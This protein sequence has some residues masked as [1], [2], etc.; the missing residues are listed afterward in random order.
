MEVALLSCV[1]CSFCPY[2]AIC[3]VWYSGNYEVSLPKRLPETILFISPVSVK[4][5]CT[6]ECSNRECINKGMFLQNW[7]SSL[8]PLPVLRG[9]GCSRPPSFSV[10]P[11]LSNSGGVVPWRKLDGSTRERRLEDRISHRR[12]R[13]TRRATIATSTFY[14]LNRSGLSY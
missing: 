4:R 3:H 11:V 6:D 8:W 9:A 14:P 12:V 13:E 10:L 2:H 1:V 5:H 7:R